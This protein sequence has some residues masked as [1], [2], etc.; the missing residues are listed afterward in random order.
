MNHLRLGVGMVALA[1]LAVGCGRD[2]GRV[3]SIDQANAG[4][5]TEANASARCESTGPTGS[6]IT[7]MRDFGSQLKLLPAS[8]TQQPGLTAEKALEQVRASHWDTSEKVDCTEVLFG[9]ADDELN[10]PQGQP[11]WAV[12]FHVLRK[13]QID[14]AVYQERC[15]SAGKSCPL[16]VDT[17]PR[18][19][20]AH[21]TVLVD[22]NTG[23]FIRRLEGPLNE[24]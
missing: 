11:A 3:V 8:S 1:I 13:G 21:T 2:L 23:A 4:P 16:P 22:A 20:A 10:G 9:L 18:Y 6:R 12:V 15:A 5:T 24:G 14:W 17:G 7:S 19:Y